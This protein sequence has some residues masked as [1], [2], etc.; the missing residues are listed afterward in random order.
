M[1]ASIHS[2]TEANC[3]IKEISDI[4]SAEAHTNY[5]IAQQAIQRAQHKTFFVIR[6]NKTLLMFIL[7]LFISHHLIIFEDFVIQYISVI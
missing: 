4:D 5:L 1:I 3:Y 2:P 7:L 6:R